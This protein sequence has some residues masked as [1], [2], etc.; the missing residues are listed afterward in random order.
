MSASTAHEPLVSVITP[1]YNG[2]K[3]L[4]EC[5]E[6]VLGQTYTNWEYIIV[7]N[8]S[9]DATLE[10]AQRYARGDRR[11][12][13]FT[14]P[15]FVGML[16]NHNIA[17]RQMSA[18][19]KYC[20]VVHADDWL[21]PE[22]IS[23]MVA[24]AEENPSVGIV[25]AHA[26]EDLWVNSKG[27]PCHTT[28]ISGREICRSMLLGDVYVVPAPTSLLIRA[29]L[30]RGKDKFYNEAHL[31]ADVEVL[32]EI[33]QRA[34]FG[35]VHQILTYIRAHEESISSRVALPLN[36]DILV[37]LEIVRHYGRI[38]LDDDE[39]ERLCRLRHEE[40]Y[41][42]L[43]ENVYHLREREFWNYHR[44]EL[45]R[46]GCPLNPIKL[47][48]AATLAA[49]DP[50]LEPVR[51]FARIVEFHRK[52]LDR[53]RTINR[54]H[55][56]RVPNATPDGAV[57]KTNRTIERV[58]VIEPMGFG[59]IC[60]YTY[61]L[62]EALASRG[63]RVSLITAKNYELGALHRRFRLHPMLNQWFNPELPVAPTQS[64]RPAGLRGVYQQRLKS[65]YV[66]LRIVAIV[67][68]T[69]ASLV[70]LQWP[71]GPH[72]WMYLTVLRALGRRVV[73]TA[74]D[75]LPHEY[76]Q[77]DLPRL[78]KMLR[79]V[80]R[81]I[82]HSEENERAFRRIFPEAT[83]ALDVVPHGN[84]FFFAKEAEQT[85]QQARAALAIPADARVVLFFGAIRPYKGL[86]DLIRAFPA[87][88]A[89]LPDARLLIAGCP[90]EDFA[91]YRE[92]IAS[93]GIS[94]CTVLFLGYHASSDVAKFFRAA[95][96]AV[97]P[98]RSA[99]QS[100]VAHLAFAF[101][102]PVIATRVGGLPEIIEEG[103]TG[104]LVDAGDDLGLAGAMIQLLTDA[105]LRQSMGTRASE[106]AA[107]RYSWDLIAE[108]T[109]T[110]YALAMGSRS[111]QL[112]LPE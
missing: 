25:G 67:L 12:R 49:L 10:I 105:N 9:T 84:Y 20:K 23:R 88:R 101:A 112:P 99:S 93:A 3:Y 27:I 83:P 36:T 34:D 37:R 44:H 2:E 7:N 8:R 95:D 43:G 38:C 85:P 73:Y 75:V 11:I 39:Y 32:F 90:F 81:A 50:F 78:S 91:P 47:A 13:V 28:A 41:R 51:A 69:R 48:G 110:I 33:L 108:T 80:D 94:D 71:V 40:Y 98:Y 68:G 18:D 35:F 26:L 6:S 89:L 58:V 19:A 92:A 64:S 106:V 66:M 17:F 42:F 86:A 63:I 65:A 54:S 77:D 21:F 4:S 60:H 56:A 59:G 70:H 76:T 24:A 16:Q 87:V 53:A 74:H 57:W 79:H 45:A 62:C 46:I 30:I 5:I 109:L 102:T 15:E 111:M 55:T 97:L 1:V 72:D 31:H 96:V 82:L 29:D 14:N 104:V 52:R 103:R 61:N 22:C 107:S 100:G